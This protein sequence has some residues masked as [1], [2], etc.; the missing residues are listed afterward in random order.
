MEK[1]RSSLPGVYFLSSF[2]FFTTKHARAGAASLRFGGGEY[3]KERIESRRRGRRGGGRSRGFCARRV[4]KSAKCNWSLDPLL[5]FIYLRF[6]RAF[7]C[8]CARDERLETSKKSADADAGMRSL[9]S[10]ARKTGTGRLANTTINQARERRDIS[11]FLRTI[12]RF[13]W[14][15][16]SRFFELVFCSSSRET[17]RSLPS[18][19]FRE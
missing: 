15:R 5:F 2:F 14:K 18:A 17:A 13:T 1:T 19:R 3:A 9:F 11:I 16:R 4:P 6:C 7:F 8:V 10:T 12:I